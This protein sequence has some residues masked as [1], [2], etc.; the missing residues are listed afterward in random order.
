MV[1]EFND[2][3]FDAARQ[4]GDNDIVK[5]SYG[6]HIMYFVEREGLKYRSDIK[7]AIESER[8]DEW[9][10]GQKTSTPTHLQ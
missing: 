1:T 2:W 9:L 4:P 7:S 5:T 8:F 6:Y 3:C 10:E